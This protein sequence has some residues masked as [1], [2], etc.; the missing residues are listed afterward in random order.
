M[1]KSSELGR[2][3]WEI[4]LPPAL[5]ARADVATSAPTNVGQ[6][7]RSIVGRV[8]VDTTAASLGVAMADAGVG[9]AVYTII[10]AGATGK[11]VPPGVTKDAE[12]ATLGAS[13]L[14]PIRLQARYRIRTED[15][16]RLT[17]QE[18]VLGPIC[19]ASWAKP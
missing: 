15:L 13:V 6:V 16:H 5:E 10:S 9:E 7:Q 8:F 14:E 18:E 1:G 12:A 2:V 3:P 4:L 17:G 19:G 11:A